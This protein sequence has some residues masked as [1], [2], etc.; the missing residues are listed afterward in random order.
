MAGSSRK[1]ATKIAPQR[2]RGHREVSAESAT[3]IFNFIVFSVS[4]VSLWC[5]SITSAWPGRAADPQPRLHH[6]DT[7]DTEKSAP[8]A[9]LRSLISLFSLC[10]LCLCGAIQLLRHGRVEPQIRN[11]DCTTET[12]RTQRSQRRKRDFDP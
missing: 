7:E 5:N 10:P 4:S 1:S 11:Q 2:H 9:R 8:K 6:R 3:S 12:P